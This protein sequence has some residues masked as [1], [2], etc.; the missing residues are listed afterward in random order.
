MILRTVNRPGPDQ[1][2]DPA[3]RP[4][5]EEHIRPAEP[6]SDPAGDR[7]EHRGREVLRGVEDRRRGAALR[8]REPRRDDPAVAGKRRRFGEPE[9]EPQ[10]EQHGHRGRRLEIP[11]EPLQ[12]GEDR[13]GDDAPQ[14]DALRA[15]AVEQPA[16]GDL[17][18]HV[19][20]PERREGVAHDHLAEPE[21]LRDLA[22][23]DRQRRA[24]GVVDRRHDEQ[25][26]QHDMAGVAWCAA[27]QASADTAAISALM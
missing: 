23:G 4:H 19:G 3:D 12:E 10:A 27:A 14:V 11:D 9:Q 26:Q 7:R 8:G 5:H 15:E 16:A 20:P 6:V 22:A 21:L 24:V 17:A 13:P 1:R 18:D 25:H 2:D